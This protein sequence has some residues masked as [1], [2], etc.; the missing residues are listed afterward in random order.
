MQGEIELRYT[1]NTDFSCYDTGIHFNTIVEVDAY[2]RRR[3]SSQFTE[4]YF[5][6]IRARIDEE[7]AIQDLIDAYDKRAS[8]I[9][10]TGDN[11]AEALKVLQASKDWLTFYHAVKTDHPDVV[12]QRDGH[13]DAVVDLTERCELLKAEYE[14]LMA[15]GE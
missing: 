3:H 13:M 11:W 15:S 4:G 5:S 1:R 8:A 7:E 12:A 9:Q 10:K 2:L 6:V 14:Q